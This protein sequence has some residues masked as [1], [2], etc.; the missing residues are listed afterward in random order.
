MVDGSEFT[1]PHFDACALVVIDMQADF[2]E[3]GE[4][5]VAGT[6]AVIPRV[7]QLLRAFRR[8]S[9]PIVHVIRLYDGDDVD[10][11]RRASIRA[12][13]SLVRP[14]TPGAEIAPDLAPASAPGLDSPLLLSGALQQ[15]GPNET[16]MWKPRWSAFFRTSLEQHLAATHV[17]TILVAGC[18][19]PNCP[20][21]TIYDA[22]ARDLRVVVVADALSGFSP[23]DVDQMI[24]IGAVAATTSR[25]IGLLPSSAEPSPYLPQPATSA[26]TVD[27]QPA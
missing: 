9:R 2:C 24:A 6:A 10:S 3:G 11:V 20:R 1:Q 13:R 22:T 18:N 14:G 23:T 8:S 19:F 7:A 17:D 16:V 15:A 26:T 4:N 27:V 5:P 21:A 25:V 12:G